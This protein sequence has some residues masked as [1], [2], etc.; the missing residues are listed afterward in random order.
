MGGYLRHRRDARR[1]T[2]ELHLA[3]ASDRRDPAFAPEPLTTRDLAADRRRGCAQAQTRA[4]DRSSARGRL[5][6][7]RRRRRGAAGCC[8]RATTLLE[9]IRSAPRACESPAS[10]I[11]VHGDYHLGQVLWAEGDFYI[12]D[13]EGEPDR[14]L[15]ERRRK[16]SPLK[17][18]AGHGA[19]VRLRGVCRAV[20][21]HD[22]AARPSASGSSRGHA[23]G[24]RGRRPRS[25]APT[26]TV[27]GGRALRARRRRPSATR[28]SQLFVLDK[29]LYELRYELNHRPDWVRSRSRAST[30]S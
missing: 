28:C 30:R 12:L 15:A 26:S 5:A 1:R 8:S 24:S 7:G 19:I 25:C 3:L 18:V 16:Q 23:S 20:R 17:D 29:A 6:A 14:P 4:A 22:V 2:A 27:D 10:K 21:A 13:F 9:R 11:R